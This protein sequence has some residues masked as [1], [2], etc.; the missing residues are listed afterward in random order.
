V[1][2]KRELAEGVITYFAPIR[3]RW[4]ALRQDPAHVR[5]VLDQGRERCL[6]IAEETMADVRRRLGLRP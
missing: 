1:E 3:E 4:A 5:G 2:C 6:A